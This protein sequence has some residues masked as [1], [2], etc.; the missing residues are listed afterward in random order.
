MIAIL[1]GISSCKKNNLV[2]DK[3]PVVTPPVAAEFLLTSFA[4]DYFVKSTVGS[5]FALPIGVTAV[6]TTDQTVNLAYTSTS[7][8]VLGTHFN[9]PTTLVIKAGKVLDTLRIS[10]LYAPYNGTGRVDDL[11]VK[12]TSGSTANFVGK[13]SVVLTMRAYCNVVLTDLEGNYPD[14]KEFSYSATTGA[15]TQTYGPP[16]NPYS[17]PVTVSNLVATTATSA[18]GEFGNLYD[19]GWS[20]VTFT[21]DWTDDA[22]FKVNIPLQDTGDPTIKIRT[23]LTKPST[24]S[25]CDRTFTLVCDLINPATGAI[26]NANYKFEVK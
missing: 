21:M 18:S 10:G 22:N 7:G 13:D 8:A 5:Y 25:S 16:A 23:S 6:S 1:V 9:A 3:E 20:N 4:K 14:T 26:T 15:Y 19:A 12:I 24:F 11:K 17:M 2:V